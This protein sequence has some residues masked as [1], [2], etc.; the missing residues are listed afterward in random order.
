M[1]APATA[2]SVLP[3]SN[4]LR[5]VLVVAI[6]A[7]V[8]GRQ[9]IGEPLRGRRVIL[10]P[11]IL[12]VVGFVDLGGDKTPVRPVDVVCLVI[13]AVFVTGIGLAQGA[14]MRLESRD[15]SLWGQLPVKGLWLWLLLLATR[16]LMTLVADGVDAKVAAST[17]T[18]LLMLGLS[19]LAQAAVVVPRAMSAR[20]PFAP[21]KDGRTFL[22][23]LTGSH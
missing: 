17:S 11:A 8:I 7:Y 4:L 12:T 6:I 14:V 20:I 13:G 21:E 22:A 23:G 19:R 18:I 1:W 3:M 2:L 5:I 10:L 16:V 9:L 15:G